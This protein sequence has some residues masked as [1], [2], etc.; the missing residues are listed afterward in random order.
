MRI[1]ERLDTGHIIWLF[2]GDEDIESSTND[3][4][5]WWIFGLE[6][7]VLVS[8]YEYDKIPETLKLMN[9]SPINII[10]DNHHFCV[11]N[12]NGG[13]PPVELRIR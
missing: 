10:L 4:L 3:Y 12:V 11:S 7:T 8:E 1:S 5:E 2:G 6:V 9:V 13:A